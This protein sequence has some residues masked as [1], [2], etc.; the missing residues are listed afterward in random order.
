MSDISSFAQ[1]AKKKKA[2]KARKSL[3]K[4]AE[5][6]KTTGA[7]ELKKGSAEEF[8]KLFADDE[9]SAH[10]LALLTTLTASTWTSGGLTYPEIDL[11][12]LRK[13][14]YGKLVD[15]I[16]T[17][18]STGIGI[19][20]DTP[21]HANNEGKY[22]AALMTPYRYMEL[23]ALGGGMRLVFDSGAG[24]LFITVHYSH[25]TRLKATT[26]PDAAAVAAV[27]TR[28]T[29]TQQR[30][31]A[32]TAGT[33]DLTSLTDPLFR[34]YILHPMNSSLHTTYGFVKDNVERKS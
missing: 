16:L 15:Y 26:A 12:K 30:L 14:G 9:N 7:A 19:R 23:S 20:P 25:P 28:L 11:S 17:N 8:K 27:I 2:D 33:I 22:A 24:E 3:K 13:A 4:A 34:A 18:L 10:I 5:Y 29:G 21:F 31:V 1:H 32:H 6:W